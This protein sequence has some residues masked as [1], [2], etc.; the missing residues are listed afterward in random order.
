MFRAIITTK[1]SRLWI[2][3]KILLLISVFGLIMVSFYTMYSYWESSNTVRQSIDNTLLSGAYGAYYF[4][5]DEFHD[6]IKDSTSVSEAEHLENVK[7]L[8]FLSNKLGLKYLYSMVMRDNRVYITSSS[9]TDEEMQKKTY[10]PFF[11][12]YTEATAGL[13]EAFRNKKI[14]FENQ[15]DRWGTQRSVLV[16]FT[17]PKGD[18]YF[19]GADYAMEQI[20]QRLLNSLLMDIGAGLLIY[21][22]FFIVTYF[23]VNKISKPIR[24]V[25]EMAQKISEGDYSVEVKVPTNDETKLL[26]DTINKLAFNVRTSLANLESEKNSIQHKVEEAIRESE[27]QKTYLADSVENMLKVMN[28]FSEGDLTVSLEVK[29]EDSIGKLYLGFNRTVENFRQMV[30]DVSRAIQET[31]SMGTQISSSAG[32]MAV[33][34]TRQANEAAQIV[35]A[36]EDMT[37][38][39]LNNTK[40]AET[41]SDIALQAGE[42]ARQ[43]GLAVKNTIEGMKRIADVVIHSAEQVKELGNESNQIG[44][45]V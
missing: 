22:L 9:A 12:E 21:I 16:P 40:N 45:I 25:A 26:A 3:Q 18:L 5:G 10:S 8:S 42:K 11:Q 39:I 6:K 36:V 17:T 15:T 44:E 14:Y 43:G 33:D 19:I 7:K 38:T 34:S 27:N 32:Q 28:K 37:Q 4:E 35:N 24:H 41:A 1:F 2:N 20:N 13:K 30:T 29:K 31:A 23:V